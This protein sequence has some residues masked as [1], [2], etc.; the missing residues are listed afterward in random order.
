V[1]IEITVEELRELLGFALVPKEPKT[2]PDTVPGDLK[3][4]AVE[5]YVT[6]DSKRVG[7]RK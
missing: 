7:F 4:P 2:N 3:V 6:E 5:L 1:K